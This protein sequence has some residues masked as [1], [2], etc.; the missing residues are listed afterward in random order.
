MAIEA[1]IAGG[2][3]LAHGPRL[4]LLPTMMVPIL[5]LCV[6][7]PPRAAAV[8]IGLTL[9]LM[10]VAALGSDWDGVKANPF[11]LA[12]PVEA[13]LAG[14]GIAVVVSSL[15]LATRATAIVDP[16]TGLPNRLALQARAAELEHQSRATGR[17][18]AL[19][20]GDPDNFKGINDSRGHP[21]G[22]AVLREV[23]ARI[24]RAVGGQGNPYRLGGEEFVVL[25]G[26]ASR[27]KAV[28]VAE[29]IRAEVA[30]RAIEGM[31]VR[32]SL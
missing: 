29:R 27:Q 22:D 28:E 11:G 9:L 8:G 4:S 17:P 25:I 30:S 13:V 1:G 12:Y 16:L 20:V 18:V 26:D 19:L 31:A 32:I 23:G 5:L 14:G 7:F 3:S 2:F 24:R 21:V 15:E 10:V 6:V